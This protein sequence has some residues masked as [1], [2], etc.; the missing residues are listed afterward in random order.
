MPYIDLKTTKQ[1][2]SALK[3]QLKAEFGKAI[4]CFPGKTE[5][6]L[7]VNI[8]DGASMWFAGDN[9]S[10]CSMLQVSLLGKGSDAA[11]DSMSEKLCGIMKNVLSISADR[12]YI[13]YGEV[14]HWGW[15]GGNF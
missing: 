2:D 5:R 1:L 11:F 4:E 6:W 14:T 10:D 12:V 3:N 8:E 15:N 9:S 13:K 7:M